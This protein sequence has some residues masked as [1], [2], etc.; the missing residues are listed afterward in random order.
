MHYAE[1]FVNPL[2][3]DTNLFI[4]YFLSADF[5]PTFWDSLLLAN[6]MI[7]YYKDT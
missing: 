4:F 5:M 7:I 2:L 6:D 1:L 3:N